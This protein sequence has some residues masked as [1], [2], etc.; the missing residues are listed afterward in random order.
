MFQWPEPA[1]SKFPK[2][3]KAYYNYKKVNKKPS[4]SKVKK[5][6]RFFSK[7]YKSKFAILMPSGRSAINQILINNGINRSK[8]INVPLWTSTCLLHALTAITNVS[9]RNKKADGFI[10]VHKWGITYNIDKNIISSKKLIIDDSAD[11]FPRNFYKPFVNNTKFEILSLPKLIGTFTGGIIL[12]KDKKL[13]SLLKKRQFQNDKIAKTQSLRKYFSAF[14]D[15]ENFD[16]RFYESLNYSIDHNTVENVYN[17]LPNYEL[18]QKTLTR[19]ENLLKK[20]FKKKIISDEK[21]QGPCVIFDYKNNENFKKILEIKHLDDNK[22]KF[23]ENY[24][25]CFIFPIHFGITEKVFLRT[26]HKL[27]KVSKLKKN[28]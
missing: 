23:K 24:K 16:W 17:C 7:K 4:A 3:N 5:I 25:K 9:V 11:C 28:E 20:Y 6:E 26:F 27:L 1:Y 8:I 22:N 2:N 10:I 14:K 15:K 18:N 19:R 21:R 13:Y 12:T